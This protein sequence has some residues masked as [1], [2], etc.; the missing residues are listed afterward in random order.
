LGEK[1]F[2]LI[3]TNFK[4]FISDA[5]KSVF[6]KFFKN[7]YASNA[8]ESCELMLGY[9]DKPLCLVYMEGIVL[10]DDRKCLLSVVDI[11]GFKK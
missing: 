11:S 5:S 4:L 9:N 2:S 1:R 6:N 3:N 10:G 8:K 7:I